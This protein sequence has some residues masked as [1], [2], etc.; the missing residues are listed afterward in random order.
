M[1]AEHHLIVC[2]CY[3]CADPTIDRDK[4]WEPGDP[5]P[6]ARPNYVRGEMAHVIENEHLDDCLFCQGKVQS[7]RDTARWPQPLPG[8]N[9]FVSVRNV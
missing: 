4:E 6:D 8:D 5:L 9:L 1:V 2:G 3:F 7:T